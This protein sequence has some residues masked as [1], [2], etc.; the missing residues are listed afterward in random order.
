MSGSGF[1]YHLLS[2]QPMI[3]S[4]SSTCVPL[5]VPQRPVAVAYVADVAA[6]NSSDDDS[7]A[8]SVPSSSRARAGSSLIPESIPALRF[9][10]SRK[11]SPLMFTVVEW[12]SRR[13]RM[14]VA[15]T[16]SEKIS[17]QSAKP[18]LE[19]MITDPRSYLRDSR[20]KRAEASSREK[21]R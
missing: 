7:S 12:C 21:G 16:V 4:C 18:L 10:L 11:D 14:A 20:R 19:V 2:D 13:S 9:S 15:S 8:A 6:A 5:R 17:P 1:C 3:T